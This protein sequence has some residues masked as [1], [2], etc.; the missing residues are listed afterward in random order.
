MK[1]YREKNNIFYLHKIAVNL[2]TCIYCDDIAIDFGKNAQN[3]NTKNA[4]Y[5][6]FDGHK[7]FSL[8][9]K[10]YGDQNDFTKKSWRRFVKMKVFI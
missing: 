3:H 7:C 10:Y 2:L 1:F 5:I 6:R 9:G 8:N 4:A